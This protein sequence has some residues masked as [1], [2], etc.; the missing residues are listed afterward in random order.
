[1]AALERR[2]LAGAQAQLVKIAERVSLPERSPR[3]RHS[4]VDGSSTERYDFKGLYWSQ[5]R[6]YMYSAARVRSSQKLPLSLRDC[7]TKDA[8]TLIAVYIRV[9]IDN[10]TSMFSML[11]MKSAHIGGRGSGHR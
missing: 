6:L 3:S 1:M 4:Q 2:N 8:V 7:L 5:R 9:V 11:S 10:V